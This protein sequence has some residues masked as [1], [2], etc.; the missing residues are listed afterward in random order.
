MATGARER[1]RPARLIPGDRPAGVHTTGH[2]QNIVHLH[3]GTV[4]KRAVVVGAEL[5]SWSAVMTLRHAGADTVLVTSQYRSP[6]SYG[7][8]NLGGR[9][10]FRVPI[11]TR[12]RLTRI[13]GRPTV[14]AVEI[15]NLDS[16]E[17]RVFNCDTVVFT[18]DWIP[19]HELARSAGIEIDPATK[20]P[21]VDTA[22]HT[23]RRACSPP[24]MCCI[25]STPRTSPHSMACSSPTRSTAACPVPRRRRRPCCD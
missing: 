15:E 10:M 14:Q 25:L 7:V 8:F 19:D 3:H 24:A 12:S 6:E 23:S 13:I 20:G 9:A 18:G 2:L 21:L 5:V 1:P 11:A 4:G 22:L 16:G 17:R